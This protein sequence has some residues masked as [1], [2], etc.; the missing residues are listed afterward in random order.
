MAE[1]MIFQA[2]PHEAELAAL[3][4]RVREL[5]RSH[6]ELEE[7]LDA[8]ALVIDDLRKHHHVPEAEQP[9]LQDRSHEHRTVGGAACSRYSS[10]PASW[11]GNNG[12]GKVT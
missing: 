11:H 5:E 12:S 9:E 6:L 3:R 1:K 2:D 8:Q 7:R 10:R 4:R